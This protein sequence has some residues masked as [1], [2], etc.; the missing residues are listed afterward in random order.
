MTKKK[1]RQPQNRKFDS[2][3]LHNEWI[4]LTGYRPKIETISTVI[5]SIESYV[6]YSNI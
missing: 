5:S 1:N 3:I 4:Y 2:R 6:V